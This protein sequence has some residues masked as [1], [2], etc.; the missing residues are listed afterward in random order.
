PI[1]HQ[2]PL[3]Q[4]VHISTAELCRNFEKP[5]EFLF[6]SNSNHEC[7]CMA[8]KRSI[9]Q[10]GTKILTESIDKSTEKTSFGYSTA[11][12]VKCNYVGSF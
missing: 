11:W 12:K 4:S 7:L 9:V 8:I 5:V 3:N 1:S 6:H 2:T 10:I